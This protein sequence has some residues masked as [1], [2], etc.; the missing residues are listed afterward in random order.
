LSSRFHEASAIAPEPPSYRLIS[1][2]AVTMMIANFGQPLVASVATVISGYMPD[3]AA[4]GGVAIGSFL[5]TFLFQMFVFLRMAMVGFAAQ[6]AGRGDALALRDTFWRVAFV[7]LAI[8]LV[9]LAG[10]LPARAFILPLIAKSEAIVV[11]AGEYFSTRMWTLPLALVNAV[12]YGYLLGIQ[13]VTLSLVLQACAA[14]SSIALSFIFVLWLDGRVVGLA[15][16]AAVTD[17]LSSVLLFLVLRRD[18]ALGAGLPA[19]PALFRGTHLRALLVVNRDLFVRTFALILAIA[20][21][22]RASA[23]SGEILLAANTILLTV[24]S[25]VGFGIDGFS[26]AGQ[27]LL[28]HAVGRRSPAT[29]EVIVRRVLLLAGG[30]ALCVGLLLLVLGPLFLPL[31]TDKPPVQEAMLRYLPWLAVM[32]LAIVGGF[33]FDGLFLG[34]T[35]TRETRNAMLAAVAVFFAAVPLLQG[36]WGNN[37]LWCAMLV[38][39]AGRG[40]FLSLYMPRLK[41]AAT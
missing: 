31:M 7:A 3:T 25:F 2:I 11:P 27:T 20:W 10:G 30:F 26:N 6:E 4:I 23:G 28:G 21:F 13:R 18:A 1:R 12:A 36:I 29:L 8:G 5:F 34:A 35:L 38:L 15:A 40:F 33:I 14:F 17:V 9:L 41:A 24:Q 19:I 16:A 39:M 32:P 22:M 37:G